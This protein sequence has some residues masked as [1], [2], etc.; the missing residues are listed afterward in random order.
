MAIGL[1]TTALSKL[2]PA[3]PTVDAGIPWKD[4][5]K[6][7]PMLR[8]VRGLGTLVPEE[9]IWIPAVTEGR[10]EKR[11]VLAGTPVKADTVLLELRNPVLELSVVDAEMA[12]K[13]SEADYMALKARLDSVILDQRSVA[14]T[15]HAD[16]VSWGYVGLS[17]LHGLG[18]IAGLIALAAVLF[19]RRDFA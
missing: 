3:A 13:S 2:K 10:V 16:F 11:L 15:V 17:A 7:G 6:R 19:S 18:W 14:A 5:V 4:T 12:W 9:I 8:Q 1:V